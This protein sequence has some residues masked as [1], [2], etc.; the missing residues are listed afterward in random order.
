M[1]REVNATYGP[2]AQSRNREDRLP[3]HVRGVPRRSEGF[4]KTTRHNF[5]EFV[6]RRHAIHNRPCDSSVSVHR[7]VVSNCE[8]FTQTVT[9]DDD[10]LAHL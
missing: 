6:L 4:H 8:H 3:L 1:S 10:G 7:E 9:H 5:Y 2:A